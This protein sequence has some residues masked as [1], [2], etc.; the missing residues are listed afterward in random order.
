MDYKGPQMEIPD[1][2]RQAAERN[3]E[4]SR[5]AY[6]QFMSMAKQAQDMVSKSSGTMTDTTMQI[7]SR[8]MKFAEQNVDA[9]FSFAADLAKA[10]DLKEFMEIQTKHA[11]KQMQ[12]YTQQ[13]QELSQL[14]TDAAKKAQPKT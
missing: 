4:Q 9:G 3:V 10:K 2:V 12:A 6:T 11:Q 7:Q 13:A 14:M 5:T 1:A 8:A